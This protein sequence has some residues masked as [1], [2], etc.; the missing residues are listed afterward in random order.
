MQ[1]NTGV[2]KPLTSSHEL[3]KILIVSATRKEIGPLLQALGIHDPDSQESYIYKTN[4]HEIHTLIT[5]AGMVATAYRM[6]GLFA[7][8]RFDL[9]V[10]AG[11]CGSFNR[12]IR[13][14]E[15]VDVVSDSFGDM[16]AEHG[17]TWLS[18]ADL[19]L[20]GDNGIF[21]EDGI[22]TVDRGFTG[23]SCN[24]RAVKGVTV[25]TV[26]GNAA[27][28]RNFSERVHADTES[29]EGAAFFYA[30]KQAGCDCIQ[31]R[32]VS[33]YVEP[34]DRSRWNIEEAVANLN[35]ALITILLEGLLKLNIKQ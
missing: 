15:V 13:I 21:Q 24:L 29:M 27:S 6:G 34:R 35:Q 31:I 22:I 30:C 3:M 33:N 26:H 4:G 12:D 17:E 19:G 14:G 25:N 28:I 11:I 23:L 10:N 18:M 7:R 20:T 5:G 9:A 1:N 32:A 2:P 8:H 16:G